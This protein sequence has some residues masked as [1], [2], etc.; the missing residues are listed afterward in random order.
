[1]KETPILDDQQGRKLQQK[2]VWGRS[3][4]ALSYL[5]L[6]GLFALL[7]LVRESGSWQ[8]WLVQTLPLAIFIPGL[9]RQRY[10]TYSW[11]CF[12]ILMYFTWSVTNAMAPWA[13]WWDLLIVLLTVSIFISAMM[14][15]RWLQY[16][17][18]YLFQAT[19]RQTSAATETPNTTD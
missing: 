5:G 6:L 12:A 17:G 1:M 16:Y 7:N 11:I 9:L 3:V 19:E 2:L 18:L 4:F 14:V 15:S 8:L 13:R 10:R